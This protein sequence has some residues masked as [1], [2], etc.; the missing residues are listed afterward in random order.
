MKASHRFQCR[1][2][3]LALLPLLARGGAVEAVEMTL[4]NDSMTT[5]A[6]VSPCECLIQGEIPASWFTAPLSGYIV[7]V[8]VFWESPL[9]AQPDTM[10]TAIRLYAAGVFPNAGATL[11]NDTSDPAV[12]PDPVLMDGVLNE[13]R[14]VGAA[15]TIPMRVAVAQGE[16]FVIGLEIFNDNSGSTTAPSLAYD[17]DGCQASTNT[18]FTAGSWSNACTLGVPGDWV[19]RAILELDPPVPA[20]SQWGLVVLILLTVTAATVVLTRPRRASGT[21]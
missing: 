2:L 16:S 5:P 8:Q 19:I 14:F 4:H 7:G 18:V 21:A 10:E 12:V 13:F 3:G 15:Q 6:S 20:V 1:V 9:G 17:N 11:L